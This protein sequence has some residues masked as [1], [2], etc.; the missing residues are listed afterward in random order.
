[1]VKENRTSESSVKRQLRELVKIGALT[2]VPR[3]R[4]NG[5]QTS[6]HYVIHTVQQEPVETWTPGEWD[7]F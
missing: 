5:S 1:M 4:K 6:N 3:S 2:K 7:D